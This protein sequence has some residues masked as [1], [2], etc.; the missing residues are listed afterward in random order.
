ML[1][2]ITLQNHTVFSEQ[3]IDFSANL[4]VIVGENG[5]GKTHLLK[6]IYALHAASFEGGRKSGQPQPTKSYL[7]KAYADKICGVFRPDKLGRLV[8]R[9]QG[10]KRCQV[11]LQFETPELD[12][13][14]SFATNAE[15]EVQLDLLPAAWQNV[16][17][18]YLPTHELLTIY[19][20]FV[21]MYE[22][23]YLT[24]EETWRDTCLHLAAPM[25]KG[26]REA[27]TS[28]L[29]R[30]IEEA[31]DGKVVL[32]YDGRFYLKSP[33]Q[34]N[35]EMNLVAEGVRKLAM[36]ARLIATGALMSRGILFWDEPEAN[37]NPRLIKVVARAIHTLSHS[38]IQIFIAT[39]CFFLLKELDLLNQDPKQS[40]D[41]RYIGLNLA[42]EGHAQVQLA[43][44]LHGLNHIV[45]LEEELDQYNRELALG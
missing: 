6:I 12:C 19:P 20:G 29:L 4:N 18:L 14:I 30:P 36:L 26:A 38:G 2:R 23:H 21:A 41:L 43:D 39:H 22:G 44:R 35:L 5:A 33:G 45:A 32:T 16:A 34:G 3:A 24:F 25:L 17:P 37:M 10:R 1:N 9:V 11:S 42:H 13:A 28:A 40:I 15:T 8:R 31:M 27:E 7:Q